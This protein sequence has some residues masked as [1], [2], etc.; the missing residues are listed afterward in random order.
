MLIRLLRYLATAIALTVMSGG[1]NVATASAELAAD[2]Y[3]I[4]QKV[5]ETHVVPHVIAFKGAAAELPPAITALCTQGDKASRARALTAFSNAVSAFA[6]IEFLR[7]GPMQ[8]D[9]MR[10]KLF[11]WPD[12]RG[13]LARQM[14]QLLFASQTTPPSTAL[15]KQQSA[16]LQ[17]LPALE[18]LLADQTSPL[19]PGE[20]NAT[21]CALAQS[22]SG[23]IADNAAVLHDGWV[24][25][26]GWQSK[27]L[28]P[29]SDNPTYR[30]PSEAASELVK[31]LL[32]GFQLAADVQ[33]KPRMIDSG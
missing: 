23:A 8:K 32:V 30:E 17:G 16:A 2:P 6:A 24:T 33:I 19:G 31:A 27:M 26:G 21:R 13:V 12:P 18:L 9:G 22:I 4:V 11:F 15:I 29:G 1:V 7:F 25:D 10:E 28:R 20:G 14:R 5:L 3:A